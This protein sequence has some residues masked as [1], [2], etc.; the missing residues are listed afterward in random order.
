MEVK[1]YQ[2]NDDP[3]KLN[4]S[5]SLVSTHD[6]IARE[7]ED[8]LR[9]HVI[10]TLSSKPAANYMYIARYG[11]YYWIDSIET[12]PN[13]KWIITGRVDPLQSFAGEIRQL[14]GTVDRQENLYNGYVAD[15][16]YIAKQYRQIVTKAFPNEM[17]NDSFILMTVG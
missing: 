8:V 17:N 15:G 14:T 7:G 6:C 5:L 3:R 11:R 10:V 1:L 16:K 9:P 13:S 12:F 2:T 4:K